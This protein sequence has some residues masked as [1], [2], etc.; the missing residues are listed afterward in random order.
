MTTAVP[1]HIELASRPEGWPTHDNVRTTQVTYGDL[2]PG[3]VRVLNEFMSVDPY[4][5]GRMNDVKSDTPPCA[6]NETTTG[7][8][9][10]R[11]VESAA[12]GAVGTAA[13]QIARL[14][15][16]KRGDNIGKMVVK[17]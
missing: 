11:I 15:G 13:G 6:L 3:Q 12:A 16:A 4:M 9:V 1:T 5:R 17:I 7:G 2:E 8:A 14:L 10:G